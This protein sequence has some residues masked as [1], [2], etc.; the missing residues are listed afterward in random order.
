M[1]KEAYL[2][3]PKRHFEGLDSRTWN[4][5]NL[6]KVTCLVIWAIVGVVVV[7]G[8]LLDFHECLSRLCHKMYS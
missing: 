6:A 4:V 5:L 8:L 2:V 3:D 1:G 7:L